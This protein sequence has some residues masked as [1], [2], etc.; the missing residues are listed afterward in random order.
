M[1]TTVA[2]RR[3]GRRQSRAYQQEVALLLREW[4]LAAS[5]A[6]RLHRQDPGP[7]TPADHGDLVGVPG[8]SL[9]ARSQL[10]LDVPAAV[11]GAAASASA[12]GQHRSA[13]IRARRGYG[14]EDSY[15]FMPLRQFADI[16]A[17]LEGLPGP[18][19]STRI[20]RGWH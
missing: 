12:A 18:A 7:E 16:L 3:H 11:D 4:G 8:W 1:T 17:E 2:P 13:A 10:K 5:P 6:P 15:V 19:W 9:T 20:R 14:V